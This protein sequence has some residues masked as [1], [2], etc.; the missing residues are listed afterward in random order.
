MAPGEPTWGAANTQ[1]P[2]YRYTLAGQMKQIIETDDG[3]A[4]S[5]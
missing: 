4:W 1:T 3:Q 5:A 2:W